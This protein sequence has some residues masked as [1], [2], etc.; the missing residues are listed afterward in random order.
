MKLTNGVTI[1]DSLKS[2][3]KS[4][5]VTALT[6]VNNETIFVY[7]MVELETDWQSY[8]T[9]KVSDINGKMR[10]SRIYDQMNDTKVMVNGVRISTDT[11]ILL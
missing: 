5:G 1:S 4:E 3:L 2:I 9:Y 7:E 11:I 10:R 8:I 6:V